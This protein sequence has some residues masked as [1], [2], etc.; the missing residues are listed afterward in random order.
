MSQQENSVYLKKGL[1]RLAKYG[2]IALALGLMAYIV[3]LIAIY[4]QFDAMLHDS[5]LTLGQFHPW[6]YVLL[7]GLVTSAIAICSLGT[8]KVVLEISYNLLL[9]LGGK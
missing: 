6:G 9:K 4:F 8:L 1:I 3:G 7:V 2:L 5:Q